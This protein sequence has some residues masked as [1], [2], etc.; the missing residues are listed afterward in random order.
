MQLV[1]SPELFQTPLELFGRVKLLRILG[2]FQAI[3]DI[4]MYKAS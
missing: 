2:H 1:R 4:N 3:S